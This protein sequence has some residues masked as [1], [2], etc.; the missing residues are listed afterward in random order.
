MS[1]PIDL[2]RRG[3]KEH[4]LEERCYINQQW[5]D[6]LKNYNEVFK[7]SV[8]Y[9]EITPESAKECDFSDTGFESEDV[10]YTLKELIALF[11]RKWFNEASCSELS[12]GCWF[13][14]EFQ[15][16][17][18]STATERSESIHIEC[19]ECNWNRLIK[20]LEHRDLI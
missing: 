11:E 5:S 15:I 7:V 12:Y 10:N 16:I 14:T 20:V 17:D 19:S 4:Q 2:L 6:I 1:I 13:S 9:S 3:M 8:T 18:Y